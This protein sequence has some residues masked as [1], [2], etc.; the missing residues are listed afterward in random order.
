MQQLQMRGGCGQH[1]L[2]QAGSS[3]HRLVLARC[4]RDGDNL[5]SEFARFL[6]VKG[7]AQHQ[8]GGGTPFLRAVASAM[9]M[10][11][12]PMN[13]RSLHMLASSHHTTEEKFMQRICPPSVVNMLWPLAVQSVI[14]PSP[15][16][17]PH[18]AVAAQLAALQRPDYPDPGSGV[19]TCWRFAKPADTARPVSK[20]VCGLHQLACTRVICPLMHKHINGHISGAVHSWEA[21]G[22]CLDL[23]QF[24]ALLHAPPY[25]VLLGCDEWKAA[26]PVAFTP[27]RSGSRAVQAVHI[28]APAAPAPLPPA[29]LPPPPPAL[30]TPPAKLPHPAQA[31]EHP[32][33]APASEQG[34]APQL[35][36]GGGQCLHSSQEA[37]GGGSAA[38]G[39]ASDQDTAQAMPRPCAA[40]KAALPTL[41]G[42][43]EPGQVSPP[44]PP[45]AAGSAGQSDIGV[46]SSRVEGGKTGETRAGAAGQSV[47]GR[48][49]SVVPAGLGVAA[50]RLRQYTFSFCLE[51]VEQGPQKGIW[52]TVGVRVGD[53]SV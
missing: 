24:S 1:G 12:R 5:A 43:E 13:G 19:M 39:G 36:S 42:S 49:Q 44:H 30:A 18:A 46:G 53:Y 48:S 28:R 7:D 25:N 21:G 20:A 14:G 38:E 22:R 26:S 35:G 29:P 27:S 15:L 33:P 41:P 2:V 50:E 3:H 34:M 23:Q 31:P 11:D 16:L 32:V 47:V 8:V 52:Y 17:P 45:G 10:K 9:H 51:Q 40:T 6:V 4:T 37:Q